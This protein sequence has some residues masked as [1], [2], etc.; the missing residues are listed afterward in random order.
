MCDRVVK[1]LSVLSVAVQV[2]SAKDVTQ[3]PSRKTIQAALEQAELE[4]AGAETPVA[5][6]AEKEPS[7]APTPAAMQPESQVPNPGSV[8]EDALSSISN[9]DAEDM[10]FLD[11]LLSTDDDM[12][13]ADAEIVVFPDGR[14]EVVFSFSIFR[15]LI[16]DSQVQLQP[17]HMF[18]RTSVQFRDSAGNRRRRDCFLFLISVCFSACKFPNP[19]KTHMTRR[20]CVQLRKTATSR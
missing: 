2:G 1:V 11:D 18:R 14:G 19:V 10:R 6:A 4:L 3:K 12:K 5:K 20:T 15:L 17:T 13:P 8:D 16:A 9:R 7:A